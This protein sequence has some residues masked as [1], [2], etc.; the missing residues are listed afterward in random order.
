MT[1]DLSALRQRFPAILRARAQVIQTPGNT[2]EAHLYVLMSQHQ[3]I[4]N[5]AGPDAES[6][7]RAAVEAATREIQAFVRRERELAARYGIKQAAQ[8]WV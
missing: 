2:Y 8:A 7:L 6:A 4:L 3:I 1:A 5:R